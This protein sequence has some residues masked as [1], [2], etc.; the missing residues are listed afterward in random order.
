MLKNLNHGCQW[1]DS[2]YSN[3]AYIIHRWEKKHTHHLVYD[4]WTKNRRNKKGSSE[5]D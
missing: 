4:I 3:F 5:E 1:P 2:R